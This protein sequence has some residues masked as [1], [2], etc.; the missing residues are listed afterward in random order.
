MNVI[1]CEECFLTVVRDGDIVSIRVE[2]DAL[3]IQDNHEP[4][5]TALTSKP[6]NQL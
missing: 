4:D 6:D 1:P 3:A 5:P 2:G